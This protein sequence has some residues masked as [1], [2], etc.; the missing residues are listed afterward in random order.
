MR[1]SVKFGIAAGI[2]AILFYLVIYY[3]GNQFTR[4]GQFSRIISMGI[5]IPFIAL[6]I[7]ARRTDMGGYIGYRDALRAGMAVTVII[8]IMLAVFDFLF[9]RFELA[10]AYMLETQ[11]YIINNKLD[12]SE[13]YEMM[14]GTYMFTQPSQQATYTIMRTLIAGAIISLACSTFIARRKEG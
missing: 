10:G 8:A 3:T 4:W 1:P 2:L 7:R 13:A 14:K 6:S 11:N 12:K 9:F 5:I